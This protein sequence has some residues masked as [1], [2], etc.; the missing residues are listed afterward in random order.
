MENHVSERELARLRKELRATR[1]FCI[2]SSLL[3]GALLAGAVFLFGQLKPAMEMIQEVRPAVEELARLDVSSVN[4]TLEQ[5]N[6]TLSSVNWQQVSDAI[7]SV[8]WQQVSDA[9]GSVDWQQVSDSLT[10][11]DV[12]AINE[13]IGGLDTEEISEA[14][15]NMNDAAAA[16][17]GMKEKLSSFSGLFG[18]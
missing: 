15:E 14:I 8:D 1:V 3:T 9:I 13:A 12:E 11:L 17:E 10:Q 18:N 2:L 16:I 5:M 4:L 7:G 6:A